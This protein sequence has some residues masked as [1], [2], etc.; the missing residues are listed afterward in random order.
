[1]EWTDRIGRRIKLRDL[2]ILM[3]VA[4]CGSMARA[5]DTLAIS[6]PV[7]SK[8]I[9]DL[10]HTLGVRV[11]DRDRHG[12]EPT[13]Y[14]RALLNRGLAAFDEL[15]QGVMDIEHLLDPTVGELRIGATE[16]IVAGLLPAII[17]QISRRHAGILFRVSRVLTD[18]QAYHQSLRRREFDLLLGR[19]PRS[20]NDKDIEVEPLFD[21]P[22]LVAASASSPWLRRRRIAL[23]DLVDEP[24]VLPDPGHLVGMLVMDMFQS[25]GL[26]IPKHGVVCNSISMNNALLATGR[27]LAI[28]S[29]SLMQLSAKRQS[30]KAL[31][32]DLPPQSSRVGIVTLK[33]RTPNPV[34]QLFVESA[35]LVART[36]GLT[37]SRARCA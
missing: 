16:P 20:I 17:D 28:Y 12:A 33:S 4:Q 1:M 9:A 32:V 18:L 21:E 25:C 35:R 13:I 11:L 36:Q 23:A 29:R 10:E 2:H 37:K 3:T 24:W 8:V 31:P 34:A 7:V 26:E 15:R 14:G 5:A 19:V 27:Y 30:I 6:Q 22:L